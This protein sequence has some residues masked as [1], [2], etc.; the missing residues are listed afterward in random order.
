VLCVRA[1]FCFRDLLVA[2]TMVTKSETSQSEHIRI[3][4]R[5]ICG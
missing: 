5:E 2:M 4:E 3:P 1:I